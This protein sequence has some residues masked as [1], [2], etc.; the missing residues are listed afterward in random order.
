MTKTFQRKD[1][2][3]RQLKIGLSTILKDVWLW[4]NSEKLQVLEIHDKCF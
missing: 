2:I 1:I 3:C 4:I